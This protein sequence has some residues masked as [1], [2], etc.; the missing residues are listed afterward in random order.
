MSERNFMQLLENR[1]ASGT[2]VCVGLDPDLAKIPKCIPPMDGAHRLYL[3]N[4]AIIQA[5]HDLV[6]AFKP[7]VAMYEKYGEAG[8]AALRSTIEFAHE[9]CPEVPVILDAKRGDI[10]NTNEGYV[11]GSFGQ[12]NADAIT[13]HPYLGQEA[14]Q[15]FLDQ[16]DKG[17]IVLCRTSNKGAGEFQDLIVLDSGQKMFERV[18]RNVAT[19]WNVNGNCCVVVGATYP[20]ELSH[21]RQIV[22]DMPI[23]IPGIGAQGGDLEATVKNGKDSRGRGMIINSSRGIIFASNGDDFA[24]AARRETLALRDA[25]NGYLKEAA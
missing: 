17:S 3:F 9:V 5:T 14:M 23:L 4:R 2:A 6:C 24:E 11:I 15:P 12:L 25:I 19:Q 13:L 20:Q 1:W 21:V 10:G 22:G 7:N 16:K 18:A 8:W